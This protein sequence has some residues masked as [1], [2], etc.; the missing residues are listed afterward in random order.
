MSGMGTS[1]GERRSMAGPRQRLAGRLSC[2]QANT[3]RQAQGHHSKVKDVPSRALVRVP[4]R[5]T[6]QDPRTRRALAT[7]PLLPSPQ[8]CYRVSCAMALLLQLRARGA[9]LPCVPR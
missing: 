8:S 6:S 5:I 3:T 1:A 4:A 2:G 7:R 9:S